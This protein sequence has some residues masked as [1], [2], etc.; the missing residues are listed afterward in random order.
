VPSIEFST[1]QG[2]QQRQANLEELRALD[3]AEMVCSEG[4][5]DARSS[6]P[7]KVVFLRAY[8]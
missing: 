3:T 5:E 2:L 1:E 7:M 6:V 4:E 8:W